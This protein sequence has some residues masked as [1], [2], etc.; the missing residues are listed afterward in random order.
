M[1]GAGYTF[2]GKLAVRAGGGYDASTGNG[3]LTVGLS[4]VSEIGAFDGGV[5][6]DLSR[7]M[8]ASGAEVRETVLRSQPAPLRSGLAAGSVV[9]YARYS[10]AREQSV[11]RGNLSARPLSVLTWKRRSVLRGRD[12]ET[13]FPTR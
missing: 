1:G 11:T 5:R 4:G 9:G 6:Q 13:G 2:V 12:R 7:S 8:L 10:R 3:Y